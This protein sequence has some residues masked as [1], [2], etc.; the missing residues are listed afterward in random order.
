MNNYICYSPAHAGRSSSCSETSPPCSP[1]KSSSNAASNYDHLEPL[2]S[3]SKKY[4]PLSD[5]SDS[6]TRQQRLVIN[7]VDQEQHDTSDD[8]PDGGSKCC[9]IV[10]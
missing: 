5:K 3:S 1:V 10:M 6:P 9:C 4:A 7:S 8:E 2:P